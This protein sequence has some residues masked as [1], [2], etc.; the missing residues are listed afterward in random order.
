[1]NCSKLGYFLGILDGIYGELTL[2]GVHI[3][4][5]DKPYDDDDPRC[6]KELTDETLKSLE[7]HITKMMDDIRLYKKGM[8]KYAEL[9]KHN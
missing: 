1:M 2:D 6:V 7:D 3:S 8:I 9:I 5:M 4:E